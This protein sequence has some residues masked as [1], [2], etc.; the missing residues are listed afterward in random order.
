VVTTVRE[1][2]F[3]NGNR[4]SLV[5]ADVDSDPARLLA[6]LGLEP[7]RPRPVIAVI[8]GAASLGG[9]SHIRAAD[10]VAPAIVRAAELTGAAIVDGGTAAGIMA[11]VGK[12]VAERGDGR[13]TLLGVAPAELVAYPG[14]GSDE[15][16]PLE[17]NHSHFVLT[18]GEDWGAETGLLLRLV[19]KLAGGAPVAA[20]LVG[21]GSIAKAEAVAAVRRGWTLFVAQGTGGIADAVAARSRS[22]RPASPGRLRRLLSAP[23][24]QTERQRLSDPELHEIVT[25]GSLRL[26]AG[27]DAA[28]L[29]REL[30][31][32]LRDETTLKEVWRTFAGYD[33]LAN[34]A[35]RTFTRFQMAI[36]LT[37]IGGTF[38]AL[39]D[40]AVEISGPFDA[41]VHWLVVAVPVVLS[42]L[43]ALALR[44]GLGK[45]WVL[46]RGAAEAA[47]SEIYRYR[48]RTGPYGDGELEQASLSAEEALAARVNSLDERLLGTEAS[49]WPLTPYEG[50]L[51]PR[52]YGASAEDDGLSRLDADRYLALRVGDQLNYFHPKAAIL[53]RRLRALQV[54][55]LASGAVGTLLA[56]A[57]YE[58]WIGLTSVIAANVVAYLGFLQVEPT[59]VLFNQAAAKLEAVSRAWK[60]E[61]ESKRDPER[62]VRDAEA[63]LMTELSGWV[64]QMNRAV[65]EASRAGE[66]GGKG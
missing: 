27:E 62:L 19:E 55:A 47:K 33:A 66:T 65:E 63:V 44:F 10:V 23:A 22:L 11:I 30:A 57:G 51:P 36:L 6:E 15:R 39:L 13:P 49:S 35:N 58:V 31:W 56:A 60:A 1:V 61:P 3:E 14:A 42:L 41:V 24:Q 21:G 18:P 9:E 25:A 20:V 52:M 45:R 16:V 8:G 59:L 46:L 37:G 64:E 4:A 43:I 53:A 28:Q 54:V 40:N 34:S 17:P 50:P 38:L 12:A 7:R 2:A 32:E 48:T 29:A 26:F 5:G